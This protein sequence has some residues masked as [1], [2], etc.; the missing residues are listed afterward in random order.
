MGRRKTLVN[1]SNDYLKEKLLRREDQQK[2]LVQP[3]VVRP[4]IKPFSMYILF[5]IFMKPLPLPLGL[6]VLWET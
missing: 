1:Y 3:L 6:V 4:Q 2:G 5:N